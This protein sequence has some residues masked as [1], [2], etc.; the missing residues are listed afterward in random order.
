MRRSHN[1]DGTAKA[2]IVERLLARGDV[3]RG[4]QI[5]EASMMLAKALEFI[6]KYGLQQFLPRY[7]QLVEKLEKAQRG[8]PVERDDVAESATRHHG[9]TWQ[10]QWRQQQQAWKKQWQR[11]RQEARYAAYATARQQR[12][13]Q[14]EAAKE[15]RRQARQTTYM[16]PGLSDRIEW[17]WT[18]SNSPKRGKAGERWKA[19]YGAE[20]IHEMLER[21]GRWS[22][23]KWNI[24][25]QLMRVKRVD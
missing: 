3:A 17:L 24:M 6:E 11:R 21:G 4:S 12:R 7:K 18:T 1:P 8:E 13:E 22:D 20:T 14:R 15:Q 10:S 23:V 5:G 25:H 9:T 19:Y 2:V 16:K